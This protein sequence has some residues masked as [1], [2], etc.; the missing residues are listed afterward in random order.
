MRRICIVAEDYPDIGQPNYP[1][2]QELA[3]S[4]SNEGAECA[5]IA[6]QSISKAIIRRLGLKKRVSSD[7]NPE[8]KEVKVYRPYTITFS[9]T[10]NKLINQL[11]FYLFRKAV[12]R[13]LNRME[14][15]DCVYCYFWHIGLATA[16]ALLKSDLPLF[17]QASECEID[18]IQ[19]YRTEELLKRVSGVVCASQKNYNESIE[20][21]F[22]NEKSNITIVPNGFRKDEFFPIE[23]EKAR[24]SLGIDRELFIVAFVGDFNERK[25]TARL[26]AAIDRFDDVYS[27]FLG[28]QGNI[29]PTCRNI[30]FQGSVSHQELVNYL[31]CA[32]IFVLP[33]QAEGCCNAIIE[34]VACG[35]PVISSNKSFNDEILDN[36]YS[37]RIDENNVDEITEAIR[38]LKDNI[39]KRKQMSSEAIKASSKFS[40]EKR[41][42]AIFSFLQMREKVDC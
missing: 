20:A 3:Y 38:T 8:G 14:Q 42:K 40:I 16:K 19:T 4:L 36:S 23:K 34:A 31:N 1:F 7:I 26:S 10:R 30:I 24:D 12:Q 25:G 21:G 6:P 15:P 29:L 18:V 11:V 35:L 17:V 33:T 39:Q 32:D 41:A 28:Q 9:N 13:S 27:I 37:I 2:V 5:V 22:I